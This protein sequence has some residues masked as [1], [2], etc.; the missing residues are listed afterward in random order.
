MYGTHSSCGLN[1]KLFDPRQ[2]IFCVFVC[3]FPPNGNAYTRLYHI[4]VLFH[5]LSCFIYICRLIYDLI[6]PANGSFYYTKIVAYIWQINWVNHRYSSVLLLFYHYRKY[7]PIYIFILHIIYVY[8]Y[9]KQ[10]NFLITVWL[11]GNKYIWFN[12]FIDLIL[13]LKLVLELMLIVK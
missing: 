10:P 5:D 9:I 4:N 8:I 3:A 2:L 13:P 1:H 6:R 12:S 7:K 11:I